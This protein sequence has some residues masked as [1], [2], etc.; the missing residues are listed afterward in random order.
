MTAFPTNAPNPSYRW[1]EPR[2]TAANRIAFHGVQ[3]S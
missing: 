1:Y 3:P 2:S